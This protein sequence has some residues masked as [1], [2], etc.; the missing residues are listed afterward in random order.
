M[1]RILGYYYGKMTSSAGG[2]CFSIDPN[3][4]WLQ[5]QSTISHSM[6]YLSPSADQYATEARSRQMGLCAT[7]ATPLAAVPCTPADQKPSAHHHLT[8]SAQ[9]QQPQHHQLM[10]INSG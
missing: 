9:H 4:R 6:K 10:R 2:D 7:V 5:S 3:T 8:H 1:L